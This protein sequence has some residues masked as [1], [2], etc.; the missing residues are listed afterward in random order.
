MA[1]FKIN[2]RAIIVAVIQRQ[3]G[4]ESESLRLRFSQPDGLP[5]PHKTRQPRHH[6]HLDVAVDEEV[7]AVA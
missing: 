7:A 3:A 6:V 2:R 1:T 5:R 4:F